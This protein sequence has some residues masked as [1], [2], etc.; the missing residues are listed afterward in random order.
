MNIEKIIRDNKKLIS[1][2]VPKDFPND[3]VKHWN[4]ALEKFSKFWIQFQLEHD[5]SLVI[6]NKPG[7]VKDSEV[8]LLVQ[9]LK[10]DIVEITTIYKEIRSRVMK[11]S[12]HLSLNFNNLNDKTTKHKRY[13]RDSIYNKKFGTS[14]KNIRELMILSILW[15]FNVIHPV[16]PQTQH[17]SPMTI[18]DLHFLIDRRI[19]IVE[20]M[21]YDVG[22][23]D[24]RNWEYEN[25]KQKP[26]E[27]WKDGYKRIF[28]YPRIVRTKF[29][30]SLCNPG[31]DGQCDDNKMEDWWKG[32]MYLNR[33]YDVNVE[34]SGFWDRP[35]LIDDNDYI[36]YYKN[37]SPVSPPGDPFDAIKKLFSS[38]EDF[39]QRNHLMCDHVIHLL[40]L[41]ALLFATEK[42][43]NSN[44]L[45]QTKKNMQ[46][47][48]GV[49]S[50]RHVMEEGKSFYRR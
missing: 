45:S 10:V 47:L 3:L 42:R 30:E 11:D 33:R 34:A 48:R 16:I 32:R 19:R 38:S 31:S 41:E 26:T 13:F 18:D 36:I 21:L 44:S 50:D 22:R 27:A 29:W 35:T 39:K 4:I 40:H 9:D 49:P 8:P 23:I 25:I 37:N 14:P 24:S 28:E 43:G 7:E 5:N 12:A 17:P 15:D 20:R 1:K 6:P 2:D 46:D